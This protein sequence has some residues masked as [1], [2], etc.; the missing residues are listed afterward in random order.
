MANGDSRDATGFRYECTP[1]EAGFIRDGYRRMTPTEINTQRR[2][3]VATESKEL[4]RLHGRVVGGIDAAAFATIL[5]V[6]ATD[7]PGGIL[8]TGVALLCAAVPIL[9]ADIFFAMHAGEDFARTYGT[10]G[11]VV[12]GVGV[13]L[14]T[15]GI[16]LVISR[17]H[18]ACAVTFWVTG[19]FA[20][21]M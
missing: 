2:E 10:W 7:N 16:G 1:T 6:A 15:V 4:Q 20:Y 17:L 12:G 9:T 3:W 18:W 11:K 13:A 21:I 19:V 8:I 5:T 14:A